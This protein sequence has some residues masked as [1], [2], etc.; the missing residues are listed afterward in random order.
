[1]VQQLAF[2]AVEVT[3]DVMVGLKVLILACGWVAPTAF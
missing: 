2:L 3:V 1:M